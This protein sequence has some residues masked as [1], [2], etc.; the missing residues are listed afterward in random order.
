MDADKIKQFFVRHVEKM[1][2][3]VVAMFSMFLIYQGLQLEDFRKEHQPETLETDATQVRRQIDDDHTEAIIPERIPSFN[4]VAR[5]NASQKPVDFTAYRLPNMWKVE[6]IDSTIRR[7]DPNILA[8]RDLIV[9]SYVGSIAVRSRTGSYALTSLE[10]AEQ[11]EKIVKKEP[12]KKKKRPRRGGGG[13]GDEDYGDDDGDME[14]EMDYGDGFMD[15]DSM[16]GASR[17]WTLRDTINFG[18]KAVPVPSL[19]SAT[20]NEQPVPDIASFIVGTAVVP[21][22]EMVESFKRSLKAADGYNP[23]RD[24]PRYHEFQ[25]QRADVT[26][27]DVED[28]TDDDWILRGSRLKY[29]AD[30]ATKWAGFCPEVLPPEFRDDAIT[31]YIPP[32]LIDDYRRITGHPLIPDTFSPLATQDEEIDDT[33]L[34]IEDLQLVG[35]GRAQMNMGGDED[36]SDDMDYG[37]GYGYGGYS[38]AMEEDPVDYKLMRFYDFYDPRDKD[39]PKLGRVYVYRLRVSLIDPNFPQDAQMQPAP[40]VLSADVYARIVPLLEQARTAKDR[41][42][43]RWSDWSE[44]SPPARLGSGEELYTGPITAGK[45]FRVQVGGKAIDYE[46]DPPSVKVV[47]TQLDPRLGTRI[48]FWTDISEGSVLS[49]KGEANVLDPI[50]LEVKKLPD[51]KVESG[52]TV[53]DLDGGHPLAIA[54]G[55]G[56]TE[57]GM[58]LFYDAATGQLKVTSELSEQRKYRIYSYADDRGL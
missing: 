39:S 38:M 3:A 53:I 51:A 57:P 45:R 40:G 6:E 43:Q 4:I 16:A 5:T 41:Q 35:P 56:M 26:D 37:G 30:A 29:A 10:A 47:L 15:G 19:R 31:T 28:L 49:T 24:L 2:L 14:G 34:N 17:V 50:S 46:R 25:V 21:H 52:S 20:T 22:R 7:D 54:E 58:M 48:P 55:E 36:Y 23:M 13:Y 1:I 42:F 9:R 12:E 44:P 11:P 8:P 33:P 32:I 18:I 27:R